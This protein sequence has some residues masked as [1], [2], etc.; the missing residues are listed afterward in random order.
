LRQR[1]TNFE[2]S[3]AG[4]QTT[5]YVA[6]RGWHIDIGFTTAD[7]QGPLAAVG[8][9]IPGSDYLFFGFGDRH[10][11]VAKHK[12]FPGLLAAL[13]P[14]A[15]VVLVTALAAAPEAAFGAE[16][17]IRLRV[18]VAAARAAQAFVW[19][20]LLQ[21]SGAPAFYGKGPYE[22]SLFFGAGPGY[23]A[24]HTCNTWVAEALRSA[25]LAVHSR[26]VLFAWQL[27]AQTRRIEDAAAEG[28][29]EHIAP[30]TP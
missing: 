6:R 1:P 8:A 22:G 30:F 24:L 14:G 28:G 13:W 9:R 20:S 12:N 19:N 4:P 3:R 29:S 16:N 25:G 21:E 15:G 27:W 11:L 23:S 10:Y 26:G 17:V 7:L 2:A 5:I 18:S